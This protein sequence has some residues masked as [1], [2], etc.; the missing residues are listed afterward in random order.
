MR[1]I[2]QHKKKT[3][4]VDEIMALEPCYY[5]TKKRVT[6]LFAGR[7][8]LN[9]SQI[10]KLDLNR[11]MDHAWLL[12]QFFDAPTLKKM[13]Y[14]ELRAQGYKYPKEMW[15]ELIGNQQDEQYN[16]WEESFWCAFDIFW[17]DHKHGKKILE[18]YAKKVGLIK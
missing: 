15:E 11:N 3:I 1:R 5:Y 9:F 4:S 8:R 12:L 2:A 16:F 6:T 10:L 13:G 18:R 17:D 14:A 7:K